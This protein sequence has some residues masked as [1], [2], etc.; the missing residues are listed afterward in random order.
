[1]IVLKILSLFIWLLLVPAFGGFLFMR[2]LKENSCSLGLS[3]MLGYVIL[4]VTLEVVGIPIVLIANYNGYTLFCLVFGI[5]LGIG[6]AVSLFSFV[7]NRKIRMIGE[8]ITRPFWKRDEAYVSLEGK[9]LLLLFLLLVGFQM[10]M[11]F[12]RA[13]FDGDDAYYAVHALQA[14][15]SKTLY[16]INPYNGRSTTLDARHALALFPIWEAFVGTV[17]GMHATIVAHSIVPLILIPLSYVVY[18]RIGQLLFPEH[19]ERRPVFLILMALWQM[20]GNVSIYTT[21]TFF[22]TRTWQGKAFT[23]S[24]ILPMVFFIYMEMFAQTQENSK[25]RDKGFWILLMLNL[26]AGASSSL[27]VLLCSALTVGLGTLFALK[28][29][30]LSVLIKS[31]LSCGLGLAYMVLYVLL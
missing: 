11:A 10:Y 3:L 24:F 17:S 20:F 30:K 14:Q 6:L 8:S 21:E 4:F 16:R 26:A 29:R 12:T 5:L 7:R 15:Q 31:C 19:P 22:L 23:G 18:G 28:E 27:A 25:E 9:L 2:I 13:S 1:M